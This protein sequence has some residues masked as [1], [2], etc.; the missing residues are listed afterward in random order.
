MLLIK[1]M[2]KQQTSTAL[3]ERSKMLKAIQ[4][5]PNPTCPSYLVGFLAFLWF[6]GWPRISSGGLTT[7]LTSLV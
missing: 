1:K 4:Y 7:S 5:H 3:V 2:P 6:K